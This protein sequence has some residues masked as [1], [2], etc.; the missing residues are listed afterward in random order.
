MDNIPKKY[1][2][3]FNFQMSG[4]LVDHLNVDQ[5]SIHPKIR[6]LNHTVYYYP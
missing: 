4:F 6:H 2:L 5:K 1:P 3:K